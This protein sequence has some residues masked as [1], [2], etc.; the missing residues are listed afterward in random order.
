MAEIDNLAKRILEYDEMN[1]E[2]VWLQVW[3]LRQTNNAHQARFRFESFASR[4][5]E[6]LNEDYPY[7][8]DEFNRQF[9][10]II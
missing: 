9:S 1:E 7:D 5:K 10:D 3:V 4:Y 2:A 6:N 8:F